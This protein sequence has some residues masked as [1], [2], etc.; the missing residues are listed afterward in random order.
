MWF[1]E[2]L[3]QMIFN[4]KQFSLMPMTNN[5]ALATKT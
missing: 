1:E 2:T 4:D 3:V 5:V